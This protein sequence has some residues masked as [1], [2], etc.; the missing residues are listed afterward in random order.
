M[1]ILKGKKKSDKKGR[2]RSTNTNCRDPLTT[3]TSQKEEEESDSQTNGSP[4]PNGSPPITAPKIL[5][6][7]SPTYSPTTKT[8][9]LLVVFIL[10]GMVFCEY[11][12]YDLVE[13]VVI[14]NLKN[15]FA[16]RRRWKAT[17]SYG[18][19]YGGLLD[20]LYRPTP[21]PI[22]TPPPT[23]FDLN[24]S[25]IKLRENLDLEN[26]FVNE[27]NND[28]ANE[29]EFESENVKCELELENSFA[30]RRRWKATSSYVNG[31][32]IFYDYGGL[33]PTTPAK[34]ID[35]IN[36]RIELPENLDLQY[37]F[38]FECN[39]I[40]F[41]CNVNS[42][43]IIFE[44]END[45]VE[46]LCGQYYP[47]PYPAPRPSAI[48]INFN[49]T[50]I[51]LCEKFFLDGVSGI[52]LCEYGFNEN[53][54]NNRYYYQLLFSTPTSTSIYATAVV[55][56]GIGYKCNVNEMIIGM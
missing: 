20:G 4:I 47:I 24:S 11:V 12:F 21:E 7:P 55:C 22:D 46:L 14:E 50:D 39:G 23:T 43:K 53:F 44:N 49:N 19:E 48:I 28:M 1:V 5:P 26:I 3:T 25:R 45:C 56:N 40:K 36:S 8:N 2:S 6:T 34:V 33:C 42:E 18:C 16:T 31:D 38:G 41:D 35:S 52:V 9:I 29:N 54:C 15:S 13:N 37:I 30:T 10:C 17:S 27:I 32:S 51:E